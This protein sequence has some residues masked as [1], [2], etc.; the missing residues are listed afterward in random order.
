MSLG[1]N[2]NLLNR[3]RELLP[4]SLS[5]MTVKHSRYL[6]D[7]SHVIPLIAPDQAL[8]K[9]GK[10]RK[11]LEEFVSHYPLVTFC[12]DQVAIRLH[13]SFEYSVGG[14]EVPLTESD[15]FQD[16][17]S[18]ASDL[19]EKFE[20]LPFEY[21]ATLILPPDVS[22]ALL[23][24]D[25]GFQIAPD[26]ALIPYSERFAQTYP[27]NADSD[28]SQTRS[29]PSANAF[30]SV[31]AP[32]RTDDVSWS[33]NA[34]YLQLECRGYIDR[35]GTSQPAQTV[36]NLLKSFFG[37]CLALNIFETKFK[38][39][40]MSDETKFVV[41]LRQSK[42]WEL[43]AV[44]AGDE[45]FRRT[46]R[47]LSPVRYTS[48]YEKDGFKRAYY[49]RS[50]G[51]IQPVFKDRDSHERLLRAA[52]WFFDGHARQDELLSFVQTVIVLEVLLGDKAESDEMGL[53]ALLKNRAAYLIANSA[54]DR[55]E[56]IDTIGKIYALR[57]KIVHSG[58]HFFTP[59]E[60][61]L[62]SEL[63]KIIKRIFVKELEL[64][65]PDQS[66]ADKK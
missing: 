35:N 33:D 26:F 18:L 24:L 52:Q 25:R 44:Y 17:E 41:H 43:N 21:M 38:L 61:A 63:R 3:L 59:Q 42:Q 58:K 55:A 29:N 10:L 64:L 32:G 36:K 8:P 45:S 12:A 50:M 28:A 34:A 15:G 40:M 60:S 57:S 47:E 13:E 30:A 65:E 51:K 5:S 22:S 31:M 48:E 19:I 6:S 46:L 14:E 53:G 7:F 16:V 9:I 49:A 23:L 54:T 66:S 62:A 56:L 39:P 37:F 4:K 2:Q 20:S 27:R 1:L 11:K